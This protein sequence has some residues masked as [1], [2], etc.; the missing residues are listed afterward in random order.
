MFDIRALGELSA[1]DNGQVFDL[2]RRGLRRSAL[3]LFAL[4]VLS[5]PSRLSRESACVRLWPDEDHVS[6]N[7]K[8]HQALHALR[9]VFEPD[10]APRAE[11]RYI[12]S[13][14][15]H[16]YFV[17][18]RR[19]SLDISRF[20]E[21]SQP[22]SS[23]QQ[24]AQAIELYRGELLCNFELNDSEL[25]R[26]E[27]LKRKFR[28]TA[29]DLANAQ[30]A[31]NQSAQ[32]LQTLEALLAREPACEEGCF[33]LMKLLAETGRVDDALRQFQLLGAALKRE[34]DIEPT[35]AVA[36]FARS[37]RSRDTDVKT[38]SGSNSKA[39]LPRYQVP[40]SLK[41]TIE[42][43]DLLARV[44]DDFLLRRYRLVTLCGIGG[45]GKTTAAYQ[46]AR[47]LS[48]AFE[49]GACVVELPEVA[50]NE[51]Q[52]LLSMLRALDLA[53]AR[54]EPEALIVER[55]RRASVLLLLD[56]YVP[57]AECNRCI[58]RLLQASESLQILATAR[59]PAGIEGE[60][61]IAVTPLSVPGGDIPVTL[62]LRQIESVSLFVARAEDRL[63]TFEFSV[64]NAED[65]A[66][67]CRSTEGIPL[68]IELAANRL[69]T[70]SLRSVREHLESMNASLASRSEDDLSVGERHLKSALDWAW[71]ATPFSAQR[72]LAWLS[73][74]RAS[75][76]ATRLRPLHGHSVETLDGLL[77]ALCEIGLL[78]RATRL[79]ERVSV[80]QYSL[81][82]VVRDY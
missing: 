62:A 43:V 30:I 77:H 53:S 28:Q 20:D 73:L 45:I 76:E 39:T 70:Q 16:V 68:A 75:L 23:L 44:R 72:A 10:L 7:A 60:R 13:D 24:K 11:S 69:R 55:V 26:R 63:G 31:G 29:L 57:S 82:D 47:S 67:I 21:F 3:Q 19:L 2:S 36:E 54:G 17:A 42:R 35:A 81:L 49:Q 41:R 14:R 46:I 66:A 9:R 18:E 15:D 37:L 56:N 59:A 80:P 6:A 51:S 8:L 48:E 27:A 25:A 65:I 32:A 22:Q 71:N 40:L 4:L 1:S 61:A 34:I 50:Q 12:A 79:N 64:E 33:A 74:Q 5:Y 38:A 78:Q 52:L 58:A